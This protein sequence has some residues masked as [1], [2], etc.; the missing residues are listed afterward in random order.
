MEEGA[1]KKGIAKEDLVQLKLT[2]ECFPLEISK[3]DSI[4]TFKRKFFILNWNSRFNTW[5][6][7]TT[8]CSIAQKKKIHSLVLLT[9]IHQSN[10]N[11]QFQS[12]R[13]DYNVT[14]LNYQAILSVQE[15]KPCC[16]KVQPHYSIN[17]VHLR[18]ISNHI[19]NRPNL[20]S[21]PIHTCRMQT[22]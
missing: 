11:C 14:N 13:T 6:S 8:R 3:I 2:N 20:I 19:Q 1:V 9:K 4:E 5:T 15:A 22:Q 12:K 17:N 21:I 16:A 18:W 10:R 7:S